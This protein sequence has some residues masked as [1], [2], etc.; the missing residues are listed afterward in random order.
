MRNLYSILRNLSKIRFIYSLYINFKLLPFKQAIRL[1]IFIYPKTILV[2]KGKIIFPNCE[3]SFGCIKIGTHELS[4]HQRKIYSHIL[5]NGNLF[6]D[7]NIELKAGICCTIAKSGKLYF[8]NDVKLGANTKIFCCKE[9][10]IQNNTRIGYES[11][12]IDTNFHYIESLGSEEFNDIAKPITIGNWCWIASKVTINAGTVLPNN[13]IVGSN[14]LLNKDYTS[15]VP[16]NSLLAGSP[17]KLI[18]TG[19]RR[20]WDSEKE[21][22]LLKKGN[23]IW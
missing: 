10:K 4:F 17:A 9:I 14:S 5:N 23:I 8:K 20:I 3:L 15:A 6:L 2:N 12:L 1:P 21:M 11:H 19:V 22:E 7:K 18:K 13:V 16:E